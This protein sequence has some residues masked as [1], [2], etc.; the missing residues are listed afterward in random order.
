MNKLIVSF[1]VFMSFL[2]LTGC[3]HHRDVRPGADGIHRVLIHT[4][5]KEEAGQDAIRQANHFCEQQ[6]KYAAIVDEKNNY[7]GSMKEEDY[8][9][10]KTAAKVA[11]AVGGAGWVFGGKNESTAGGIVGLGGGIA[12]SVIGKGYTVEMRFKC[13]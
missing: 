10:A 8:K 7:V 4:D 12:D 6:N 2:F 11:Q 1:S 13:Q 5:N 3:A 9:N